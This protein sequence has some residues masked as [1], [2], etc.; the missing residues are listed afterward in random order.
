MFYPKYILKQLKIYNNILN[1]FPFLKNR[2]LSSYRH[3]IKGYKI[4]KSL[5]G[6]RYIHQLKI[7][8]SS[9]KFRIPKKETELYKSKF[10]ND[11]SISTVVSQYIQLKLLNEEINLSILKSFS[12]H[13][14]I[15]YP[16]PSPYH[17]V[18][19]KN[20]L[21]I[22][23]FKSNL[24]WYLL[25]LLEYFEGILYSTKYLIQ[26]TIAIVTR[27]KVT[28]SSYDAFFIGLDTSSLPIKDAIHRYDIPHQFYK[29][30]HQSNRI[31][32]FGHDNKNLF[33]Y[34]NKSF[35]LSYQKYP[36][37]LIVNYK[38]L[39]YLVFFLLYNIIKSPYYLFKGYWWKFLLLK[40]FFK[41]EITLIQDNKYISKTYYFQSSW[42]FRPPWTYIASMK[43]SEIIFYFYSSNSEGIKSELGYKPYDYDW[44]NL[45]WP[46]YYVWDDY[47]YEFIRNLNQVSPKYKIN[48][49]GPISLQAR[50]VNNNEF[51]ENSIALFDISPCRISKYISLGN[52]HEY[53]T[54]KY[55]IKFISDILEECEKR[56]IKLILKRK[57]HADNTHP[58]Y[59]N[60]LSS[61]KGNKNIHILSPEINAISLVKSTKLSISMP[62][63]SCAIIGLFYS[64]PSCYYDPIGE[65]YADDRASHGIEIV[66]TPQS[67]GSW[68]DS[69]I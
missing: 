56:N 62:F 45:T 22:D 52:T 47:Q 8:L 17:S 27:T 11:F 38:K 54:P 4:S 36:F 49:I 23:K 50:Y 44:R 51:P 60:Y 10:G 13:K 31:L 66:Q 14:P 16:L 48:K 32:N 12:D 18:F 57:R 29:K 35:T 9:I 24:L 63:T 2:A 37:S 25:I 6:L 61:L 20:N 3:A 69:F 7:Q 1:L 30:F 33:L 26:S 55:T 42:L 68:L 5:N 34:S 21:V 65:I 15:I 59:E 67:L 46:E 41:S 43:F 53:Y 19:K 28:L 40:E 64:R 58:F 39:I